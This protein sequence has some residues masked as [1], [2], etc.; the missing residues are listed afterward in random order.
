MAG[1][2]LKL[3]RENIVTTGIRHVAEGGP[4]TRVELSAC[5]KGGQRRCHPERGGEWNEART[6]PRLLPN[7]F[8]LLSLALFG[9]GRRDRPTDRPP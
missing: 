5:L 3:E 6:S 9:R 1:G 4:L 7:S 8:D 2:H